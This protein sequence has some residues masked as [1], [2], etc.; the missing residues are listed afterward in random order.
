[1]ALAV[2]QGVYGTGTQDKKRKTLTLKKQAVWTKTG[3]SLAGKLGAV[4]VE[5]GETTEYRKASDAQL[6]ISE[7]QYHNWGVQGRGAKKVA[8]GRLGEPSRKIKAIVGT[9]V[10]VID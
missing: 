9:E 8:F 5:G 10:A 2:L 3:S 7:G 6:Q 1:M 4:P